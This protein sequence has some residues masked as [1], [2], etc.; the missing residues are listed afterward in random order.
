MISKTYDD[1]EWAT[2]AYDLAA[3]KYL[4]PSAFTSFSR[5][6]VLRTSRK[7]EELKMLTK[8]SMDSLPGSR[9][10][11]FRTVSNLKKKRIGV[12]Y[13]RCLVKRCRFVGSLDRLF[14]RVEVVR[15]RTNHSSLLLLL[16]CTCEAP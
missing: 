3:L 2:R 5:P 11:N 1:E 8:S 6:T 9:F 4:G 16:L 13:E 14:L 7:V 12:L 15:T 10:L